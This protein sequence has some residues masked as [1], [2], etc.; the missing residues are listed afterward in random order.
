[1]PGG[2][3][4]STESVIEP[5]ASPGVSKLPD[6]YACEPYQFTGSE[7]GLYERHLRFDSVLDA[8]DTDSRDRYE[9]FARSVRDVLSQRWIS[10]ETTTEC[11]RWRL[12]CT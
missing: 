3:Q 4:V 12:A 10:T 11:D 2:N 7:N 6:A 8:A 5:V 1:M 9:A